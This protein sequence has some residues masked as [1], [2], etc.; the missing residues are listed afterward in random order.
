MLCSFR[1]SNR[2]GNKVRSLPVR[3]ANGFG[4][5]DDIVDD[6]NPVRVIEALV[7]FVVGRDLDDIM[8]QFAR[9]WRELTDEPQLRWI[10]PQKGAVHLALASI[11]S[12][13]VDAL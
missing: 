3:L 1:A 11:S 4:T 10:G 2:D 5:K 12:A 13:L 7:P 8:P 6:D 9:V